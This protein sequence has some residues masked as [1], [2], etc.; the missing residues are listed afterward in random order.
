MAV[1]LV[2]TTTSA[3]GQGPAI[4]QTTR[5]AA[6]GRVW[7]LLKYFHPDVAQGTI[8]WDRGALDKIPRVRAVATK[9]ELNE[10]IS[11]LIRTAGPLPM[12]RA[13]AGAAIDQPEAD[14][15]FAWLDDRTD[16]RAIDHHGTEDRAKLPADRGE[17][18]RQ[19]DQ[20]Y[21][22]QSGF[23]QRSHVQHPAFPATEVRL[24]A[25]FR[26]WNMVQSFYPNRDITN[27]RVVPTCCRR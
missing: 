24:L 11:R 22:R 16:L 5:L 13:A 19:A 6:L 1:T 3:I 21:C 26:F 27:R 14:P 12:P 10:E 20:R 8:D 9:A 15:A 4:D 23:Q 2:F 7:G 25:L 18:I 17:P